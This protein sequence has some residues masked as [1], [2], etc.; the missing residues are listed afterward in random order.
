MK[1]NRLFTLAVILYIIAILAQIYDLGL[2]LTNT[3][4]FSVTQIQT[5]TFISITI[6]PVL[7]DFLSDSVGL[8]ASVLL[9]ASL[10]AAWKF[11][12]ITAKGKFFRWGSMVLFIIAF[13]LNISDT[14]FSV[15]DSLGRVNGNFYLSYWIPDTYGEIIAPIALFMGWIFSEIWF[16]HISGG[17]PKGY[18]YADIVVRNRKLRIVNR[19]I[20]VIVPL[21]VFSTLWLVTYVLTWNLLNTPS[22]VLIK[23]SFAGVNATVLF[24]ILWYPL[25]IFYSIL[26]L[27]DAYL[28]AKGKWEDTRKLNASQLGPVVIENGKLVYP[29]EK[30]PQPPVSTTRSLHKPVTQLQQPTSLQQS[31]STLKQR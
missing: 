19:V 24:M 29:S 18:G 27:R 28:S 9:I 21:G 6:Y 25:M 1:A 12:P 14:L 5:F 11:D 8:L 3:N 2:S 13:L 15:L 22:S 31:T 23:D 26:A 30:K 20:N 7:V 17:P 16:V 4:L 10:L